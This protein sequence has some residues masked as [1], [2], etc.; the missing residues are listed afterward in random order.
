MQR[1]SGKRLQGSALCVWLGSVERGGP[2]GGWWVGDTPPQSNEVVMR[3]T[4]TT[5]YHMPREKSWRDWVESDKAIKLAV[6]LVR[7]LRNNVPLA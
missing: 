7:F 5:V 6:L 2:K 1:T 4:V 3:E